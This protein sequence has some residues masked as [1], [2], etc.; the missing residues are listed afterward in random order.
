MYGQFKHLLFE[1]KENGVL[2]VTINRPEA[3]NAANKGLHLELANVWPVIGK[4]T[5]TRVVVVTGAGKAF[6]AGGDMEML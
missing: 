3:M 2:L 4:D 6:C 1:K 5:D